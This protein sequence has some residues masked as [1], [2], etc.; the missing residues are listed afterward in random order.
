[1]IMSIS[2][3]SFS[4]KIELA[5]YDPIDSVFSVKTKE[6]N[7]GSSKLGANYF[8]I[9]CSKSHFYANEFK[10]VPQNTII[11]R[12]LF[13]PSQTISYDE[14]SKMKIQYEDN[15]VKEYPYF[16]KY[17]IYSDDDYAYFSI[18]IPA[19]DYIFS[20]NAKIIR[21]PGRYKD[22]ELSSKDAELLKN[23]AALIRDYPIQD[24]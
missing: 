5:K 4:Q 12:F 24:K 18:E 2:V 15:Q 17:H 22:I 3:F 19:D 6:F 7:I 9:V 13:K 8:A 23:S 20:H 10:D 16:G 14:D 21:I 11:V 1:M